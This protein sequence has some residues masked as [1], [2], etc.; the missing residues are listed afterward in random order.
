M[1][2]RWDRRA[3]TGI[4]ARVLGDPTS[5]TPAPAAPGERN[6]IDPSLGQAHRGGPLP[7]A[8]R[9]V[10]ARPHGSRR[11]G[12]CVSPSGCATQSPRAFHNGCPR[13]AVVGSCRCNS[14]TL[15]E[16]LLPRERGLHFEAGEHCASCPDC[17]ELRMT[18][19]GTGQE[20]GVIWLVVVS[21]LPSSLAATAGSDCL[22]AYIYITSARWSASAWRA[23]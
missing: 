1:W 22:P 14:T 6:G 12:G 5:A 15:H 2:D 13:G 19:R 11:P 23:L 17:P 21:F 4:P 16:K 10:R 18:W 7:A 8:A 3:R 20:L 9:R